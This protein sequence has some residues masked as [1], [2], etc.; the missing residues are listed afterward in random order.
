M[1][2]RSHNLA[3]HRKMK[4]RDTFEK[5][6]YRKKEED[7]AADDFRRYSVAGSFIPVTARLDPIA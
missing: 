7:I 5:R 6:L 1:K 2:L 3:P 4:K